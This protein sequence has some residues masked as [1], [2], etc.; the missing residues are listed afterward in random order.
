MWP[1]TLVPVGPRCGKPQSLLVNSR[2]ALK[3]YFLSGSLMSAVLVWL[4]CAEFAGAVHDT[5]TF[6]VPIV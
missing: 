2:F 5:E 3:S 6:T 4:F 1:L